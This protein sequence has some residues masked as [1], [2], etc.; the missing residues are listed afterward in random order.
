MV[1][2]LGIMMTWSARASSVHSRPLVV[3]T[4]VRV[5][6][7]P[8]ASWAT[9]GPLLQATGAPSPD[10][11]GSLVTGVTDDPVRSVQAGTRTAGAVPIP[12]VA[13]RVDVQDRWPSAVVGPTIVAGITPPGGALALRPV[14][15][16]NLNHTWSAAQRTLDHRSIPTSTLTSTSTRRLGLVD[17][18]DIA[19]TVLSAKGGGIAGAALDQV[20]GAPLRRVDRPANLAALAVADR[21]AR[22]YEHLRPPVILA[23][24][25]VQVAL[26][27]LAI[28]RWLR[29]RRRPGRTA[30]VAGRVI[31]AFPL[32]T[33]LV[34]WWAP[35]TTAPWRWSALAVVAVGMIVGMTGFR[36][37]TA[38]VAVRRTCAATVLLVLADLALGAH[39][40]VSGIFGSSPLLGTRYTGL[41]NPATEILL[42]ATVLWVGLHVHAARRRREAVARATGLLVLITFVVGAPWLGADVGGLLTFAFVGTGLVALLVR[43]TGTAGSERA[44]LPPR[45]RRRLVVTGLLAVVLAGAA[46]AGMAVLDALHAFG[47]GTHLGRLVQR[48]DDDGFG[49][50]TS[51][52]SR[53]V[54]ANVLGYGFPWSMVV[55][56]LA[57]AL[58]WLLLSGRWPDLADRSD[59]RWSSA[60]AAVVG[61]VIAYVLNDSG[62]VVLAL[63]FVLVGPYLLAIAGDGIDPHPKLEVPVP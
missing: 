54:E 29:S 24:V 6:L 39:L 8:G 52:V 41:G 26:F 18:A 10:A 21:S 28:G 1:A 3:P 33:E 13:A 27:L 42:L 14:A 34:R 19:A 30:L 51:V 49:A 23:Y 59:P 53:K 9:V 16:F 25:V 57:L 46:L 56:V 17:I 32:A 44:P 5:V 58:L 31:A 48:V 4:D 22:G 37:P 63:L 61:S 11:V 36:A 60:V 7:V 43:R 47:P 62:I 12:A 38:Q 35:G 20:D 45:P 50:L 15:A 2:L 55:V 40:Q